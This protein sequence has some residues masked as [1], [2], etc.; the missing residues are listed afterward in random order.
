MQHSKKTAY[1]QI[2]D[3]HWRKRGFGMLRIQHA[4]ALSNSSDIKSGS[5]SIYDVHPYPLANLFV[6][7]SHP[8]EKNNPVA[9]ND[10]LLL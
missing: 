5:G 8:V 3:T 4:P 1:R 6:T 2:L 9:L 7:A 10:G